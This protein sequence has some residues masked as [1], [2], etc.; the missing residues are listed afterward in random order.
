MGRRPCRCR[1]VTSRG[2]EPLRHYC[3]YHYHCAIGLAG[4]VHVRMHMHTGGM[5]LHLRPANI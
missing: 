4:H 1:C 2:G 3:N 5:R